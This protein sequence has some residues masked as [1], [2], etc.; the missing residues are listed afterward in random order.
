MCGRAPS[1]SL[2]PLLGRPEDNRMRGYSAGD[3]ARVLRLSVG[4]DISRAESLFGRFD[5]KKTNK[6]TGSELSKLIKFMVGDQE[7]LTAAQLDNVYDMMAGDHET[8]NLSDFLDFFCSPALAEVNPMFSTV[9][10]STVTAVGI[11]ADQSAVIFGAAD[12]LVKLYSLKDSS[13]ILCRKCQKQISAV[14]ISSNG[15]Q[16]GMSCQGGSVQWVRTVTNELIYKWDCKHDVLC[17]ALD[18]SDSVLGMGSADSSLRL[19][20]LKD[21]S[22]MYYFRC[23]APVRTISMAEGDSFFLELEDGHITSRLSDVELPEGESPE[24]MSGC[25]DY[26]KLVL[27]GTVIH[28]SDEIDH[29]EWTALHK[30]LQSTKWVLVMSA[31]V[32][33]SGSLTVLSLPQVGVISHEMPVFQS[34]LSVAF[35]F[36]FG[37]R[38]LSHYFSEGKMSVFALAPL[39]VLDFCLIG[40]DLVIISTADANNNSRSRNSTLQAVA[41]LAKTARTARLLRLC[42]LV[43]KVSHMN[44]LDGVIDHDIRLPDGTVLKNVSNDRITYFGARAKPAHRRTS[45][46]E[47]GGRNTPRQRHLSEKFKKAARRLGAVQRTFRN[48][49]RLV[50]TEAPV[51]PSTV[52][53]GE[54][55]KV[56]LQKLVDVE[57]EE[58]T[59]VNVQVPARVKREERTQLV[60]VGCE[61]HKARTW[62]FGISI[63]QIINGG[64]RPLEEVC[65]TDAIRSLR[66]ASDREAGQGASS[67]MYHIQNFTH[68]VNRQVPSF[69]CDS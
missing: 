8:L 67:R 37:L 15:G 35:A 48:S 44:E 30:V 50:Q 1:P 51:R 33:A 57:Y 25:S 26:S 20:D 59:P 69:R 40:M 68:I 6:L 24:S 49:P 2:T 11:S 61:D 60:A 5:T 41:R 23:E 22:Q 7:T 66:R 52:Q 39:N 17:L 36:E 64:V 31:F 47:V 32:I 10:R 38:A 34:F 54:E 43:D 62:Q 65:D 63:D 42:R 46:T 21:G 27:R 9:S 4:G 13:R 53:H 14:V 58:G 19:Y 18:G 12:N 45:C 29:S 28:R 55:R 16:I 3:I 56:A